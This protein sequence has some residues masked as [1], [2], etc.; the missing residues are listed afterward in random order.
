MIIKSIELRGLWGE[1]SF[2]W[3][4]DS[5][6]SVLSGINGSG[7]STVLRALGTLLLDRIHPGVYMDRFERLN[8]RLTDGS[9]L[10]LCCL[11]KSIGELRR[12]S[13]TD[14]GLKEVIETI[15]N[16]SEPGHP[17]QIAGVMSITAFKDGRKVDPEEVLD[18]FD[19]DF[20]STFDFAP[21]R[22]KDPKELFISMMNNSISELDRHLDGVVDRYRS[23]QIELGARLNKMISGENPDLEKAR[24]IFD[25]RTRFQ[26]RFDEML[27]ATGKKFNRDSG[28]VSFVFDADGKSHDYTHLSA[29]EKQLLLILLTV[30]M[31]EKRPAVLVMDEPE[32]SMHVDWQKRLIEVIRDINPNCQLIIA[33]HSPMIIMD[34]WMANVTNIHDLIT[35][36]L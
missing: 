24:E 25:A 7:K 6:V 11:P 31:Q 5:E 2:R 18:N 9:E 16:D 36:E 17:R 14:P 29:G 30:F 15:E 28:E 1:S 33:T 23:Y 22:P 8:V 34:G 26:D 27:S 21:P 19:R 32:I 10:A 35:S 20:V 12:R 4:L 13:E 3:N